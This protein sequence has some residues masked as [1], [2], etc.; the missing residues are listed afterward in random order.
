MCAWSKRSSKF[1]AFRTKHTYAQIRIKWPRFHFLI[2]TRIG[3]SDR[4]FN[5]RNSGS[6][7]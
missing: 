4:H 2:E 5:S 7:D 1:F 6:A 3:T